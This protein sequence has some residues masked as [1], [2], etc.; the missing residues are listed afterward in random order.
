MK[1]AVC[2][3]PNG[4]CLP[5]LRASIKAYAPEHELVV[6]G[7]GG[8]YPN[9]AKN[10]GDA[11]NALLIEVFKTEAEC[12]VA[13]DDVVITPYTI[14]HLLE[15][16]E[17]LKLTGHKIGWVG[18][19]SDYV[20]PAQNI[21]VPDQNDKWNN[22]RFASEGKIRRADVIAP[23]FA[24]ISKEA[25]LAAPFPPTNWYSD[26]VSCAD[27]KKL[28]YQHF[29]SRAY[30]HHVGGDTTGSD[31]HKLTIQ[32]A[33]WMWANRPEYAEKWALPKP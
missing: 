26:N 27:M 31:F 30:V 4:R 33:T 12:I 15:D 10:F 1:I 6:A 22:L 18:C 28:G 2:T 17:N 5:V 25:F 13:N 9:T 14:P 8:E 16:V 11:Y 3:T 21:R 19:R 7:P 23:I 29:V 24:W 32:A 20:L